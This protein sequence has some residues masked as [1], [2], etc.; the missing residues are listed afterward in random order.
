M[1]NWILSVSVLCAIVVAQWNVK[2]KDVEFVTVLFLHLKTASEI[3]KVLKETFV[4]VA[5]S[6]IPSN[7]IE[8]SNLAPSVE[9]VNVA[10]E[11]DW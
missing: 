1:C 4:E 9:G 5:M 2:L 10:V 11:S 8:F 3:Y 7:T 6:R